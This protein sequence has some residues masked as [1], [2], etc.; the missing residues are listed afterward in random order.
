MLFIDPKKVGFNTG[1]SVWN[2]KVR[3]ETS[4]FK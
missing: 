1:M 2:E 3:P 4:S